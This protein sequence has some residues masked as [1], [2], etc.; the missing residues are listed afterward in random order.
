MAME[1]AIL[2]AILL[3][4]F[5]TIQR[6]A[7]LVY[8]NYNT[9]R[10]RTAGATEVGAGH[11]PLIVLL[12]GAWLIA[13]WLWVLS[14]DVELQLWAVGAY[15]VLQAFRVWI[16]ASLGSFWTTR[17]IIPAE[18][19]PLVRRGPYRFCQHPNYVL[20]VLEIALLPLALGAWPLAVIFSIAN[21][22]LLAWRIHVEEAALT[23]R[24]PRSTT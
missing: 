18:A 21:A 7:E 8:A 6:G 23:P 3:L 24:R 2:W 1:G 15:L 17:V 9:R 22:L 13:L 5:V 19:P 20:V 12:H 10:L 4:L 11:Y 16:L 14:G